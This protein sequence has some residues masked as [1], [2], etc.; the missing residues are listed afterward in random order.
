ML[1]RFIFF[2]ALVAALCAAFYYGSP[3]IRGNQPDPVW[4]AVDTQKLD[5]IDLCLSS[6][7]G[8][9]LIRSASHWSVR[10]PGWDIKPFA[11]AAKVRELLDLLSS[12]RPLSYVGRITESEFSRFGLEKPR[13]EIV[14]G[15]GQVLTIEI[16]KAA[17]SGEGFYAINSLNP[18]QLFLLDK[19]FAS[20]AGE[21]IRNFCDL[22]LIHA[23]NDDVR[24]ISMDIIG[25]GDWKIVRET[26]SAPF[27]FRFPASFGP[28]VKVSNS[29]VDMLLH[30]LLGVGVKDL[31]QNA[32]GKIV[33]EI[34]SAEVGIKDNTFQTVRIFKTDNEENPFIGNSTVQ[35]GNF[36]LDKGHVDQLKKTAFDMRKRNILSLETGKV[37]SLLVKQG[38]QTV[39]AYKSEGV[40]KSPNQ[41]KKLLGIDMSL[42]RLNE[43]KFEAESVD[44]PG[45]HSQGVMTLE[46]LDR[47]G[48][49]LTK[50]GFLSDPDLPEGQCW[51]SVGN[52]TV[53]YPVSNK[54]LED[55]QGQIPLRK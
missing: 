38:N 32:T 50:V 12:G 17:P 53:F 18:G 28:D 39:S 48:N 8:F 33:S 40:W 51:L 27:V 4:S 30:S 1:K 37:G 15:G 3:N 22:H 45:D 14:T 26:S 46:I 20:L 10:I 44:K 25:T 13:V 36:V 42:W 43:L 35:F 23:K 21:S 41:E 7:S 29:E 6:G 49:S 9:S 5:R 2:L 24:S 11:D 54:L 16:G 34:L 47:D 19:E 31:V 55:L 52:G